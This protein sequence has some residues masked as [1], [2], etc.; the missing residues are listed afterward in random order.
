VIGGNAEATQSKKSEE[1]L[2]GRVK[3][4]LIRADNVAIARPRAMPGHGRTASQ[5]NSGVDAGGNR[6][7]AAGV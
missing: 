5:W 7:R 6:L 3:A 2:E 1:Q 4:T